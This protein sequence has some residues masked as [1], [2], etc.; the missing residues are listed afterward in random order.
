LHYLIISHCPEILALK[1]Q[2]EGH[3]DIDP[4]EDVDDL[5]ENK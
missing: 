1:S 3:Y 2:E 4:E 5:I